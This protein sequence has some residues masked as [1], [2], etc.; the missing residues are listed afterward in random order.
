MSFLGHLFFP[1]SVYQQCCPSVASHASSS[2]LAFISGA[3][4]V[5][6]PA[7]RNHRAPSTPPPPRLRCLV[8]T[9]PSCCF[10]LLSRLQR[11]R[12]Q[13]LQ[14][15]PAC[16]CQGEDEGKGSLGVP[17]PLILSAS[18]VSRPILML[19]I[20]RVWLVAQAAVYSARLQLPPHR[21]HEDQQT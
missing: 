4:G 13:E 1:P 10:P 17:P 3:G 6:W 9:E 12:A 19:C 16:L 2:S 5:S 20:L 14:R 15:R 8:L 7:M 11:F 21:H 18:V